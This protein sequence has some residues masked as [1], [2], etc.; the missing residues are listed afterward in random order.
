VTLSAVPFALQNVAHSAD[1]FRQA[2]SSFVPPGGGIVTTGDFTV[3]QTGTP[4]MGVS[5][6]VGRAWV[7]GTNVANVVGGNFSTQAMYFALNDA[8]FTRT[9]TTAHAVN[10]RIDVVYIAMRDS[11]Y[12]GSLNDV[13]VEVAAGTPAASPTVPAIPSNAIALA[14]VAVAANATSIVNAN[15]SAPTTA[16]H[17]INPSFGNGTAYT[18]IWTG[19]TDWG[20]GGALTGTYWV[21]GDRVIVRSRA[22][23]GASATLGNSVVKCPLPSNLP[24]LG[25][26]PVFLGNG[27]Y[28]PASG[29]I[30][31]LT[32]FADAGAA[33]VW[34]ASDPIKTPG[35]V[36]VSAAQNSYFEIRFEYQTKAA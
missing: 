34:I 7:P 18:P 13:V 17:A 14:N 36:P 3:T 23:F 32:V 5:I 35:D 16:L 22:K 12:S 6:G 15:I 25:T 28:V 24:I 26:E 19:V 11:Q 33:S 4:S 21:K 1:L 9:I 2:V 20:T 29:S 27:V 10:P 8:A 30:R 31:P